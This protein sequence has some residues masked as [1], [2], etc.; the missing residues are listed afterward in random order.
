MVPTLWIGTIVGFAS[1]LPVMISPL[2]RMQTLPEHIEDPADP[3]Q[4]P[5]PESLTES[6]SAGSGRP[7][8]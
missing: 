8:G 4:E 7:A 2:W 5:R 1:L 6:E 3:G